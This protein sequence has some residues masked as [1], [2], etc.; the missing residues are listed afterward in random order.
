[1]VNIH[2]ESKQQLNFK[3]PLV[4]WVP[5]ISMFVNL[6]LMLKLPT[7]TW[8]RFAVWMVIGFA[9]YFFY[10]I[11]NSVEGLS[12]INNPNIDYENF[13]NEDIQNSKS[14]N[15]KTNSY[16]SITDSQS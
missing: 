1:M 3:T 7:G 2:P 13:E 4:P 11:K 16:G 8:I 12:G 9:I 6:Y 15:T 5:F 10:G 14:I